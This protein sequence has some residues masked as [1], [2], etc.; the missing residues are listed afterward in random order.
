[1]PVDAPRLKPLRVLD[2]DDTP[3]EWKIADHALS[4]R[5]GGRWTQRHS[6]FHHRSARLETRRR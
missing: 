1:L 2:R 4:P 3:A 6:S 5:R